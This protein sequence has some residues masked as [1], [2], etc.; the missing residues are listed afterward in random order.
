MASAE[1]AAPAVAES[2]PAASEGA[3]DPGLTGAPAAEGAETAAPDA[4]GGE[5]RRPSQENIDKMV[6]RGSKESLRKLT[7]SRS[8]SIEGDHKLNRKSQT[9]D[10]FAGNAD[11]V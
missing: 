10:S 5:Q 9:I 6:R 2:V 1:D 8:Q 11:V 3:P 7:K 4:S